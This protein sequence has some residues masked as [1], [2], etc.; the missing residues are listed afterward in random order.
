MEVTSL[1]E[2]LNQLEAQKVISQRQ[3]KTSQETNGSQEGQNGDVTT[4]SFQNYLDAYIPS[5]Q[6]N[7]DQSSLPSDN[8]NQSG[9]FTGMMQQSSMPPLPPMPPVSQTDKTS[10][11][12]DTTNAV[13]DTNA[14]STTASS[15]DSINETSEL[16]G[17]DSTA[18]SEEKQSIAVAD[19]VSTLL[20]QISDTMRVNPDSLIQAMNELG[21][22]ATDLFDSENMEKLTEK[23]NEGAASLG[24]TSTDSLT[25]QNE[26]LNQ[27]ASDLL[28]QLNSSYSVD[29]DNLETLLNEYLERMLAAKQTQVDASNES[30]NSSQT[31][32]SAETTTIDDTVAQS[33]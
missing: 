14:T 28:K 17:T 8:Y 27:T 15:A 4:A 7:G 5:V 10:D 9:Q 26:K 31:Q 32:N 1:S 3:I 25:D 11:A 20:N 21:L 23:L 6:M 12:T 2:Y 24:L 29:N 33:L 18:S 16:D 13:T 30:Q 19:A 22:S